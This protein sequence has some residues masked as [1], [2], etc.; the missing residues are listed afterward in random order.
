MNV[1]LVEDDPDQ[2]D[3]IVLALELSFDNVELTNIKSESE[4]YIYIEAKE[5]PPID[6]VVLDIM[7]RWC[8]PSPEMPS[9]PPEVVE[10]G[11]YRAGL[12]CLKKINS[13]SRIQNIPVIIYTI[14]GDAEIQKELRS[15][16][17]HIVHLE[18]QIDPSILVMQIRSLLPDLALKSSTR[19]SLW[20]KFIDA[21]EAKPGWLGISV[22]LKKLILTR[23]RKKKN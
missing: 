2:L 19:K 3:A 9:P 11:H 1:L 5:N 18:K 7:L 20:K 13:G 17:H 4:F 16:P 14:L 10:Q 8:E 12:R 6:L 23:S 21:T 22:D 15:L